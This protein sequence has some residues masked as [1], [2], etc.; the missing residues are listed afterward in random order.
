MVKQP[1]RP[2]NPIPRAIPAHLRELSADPG[3]ATGVPQQI[4]ACS[5]L[6]G[7]LLLPSSSVSQECLSEPWLQKQQR[8]KLRHRGAA[9]STA[10][11]GIPFQPFH[12]WDCGTA[13]LSPCRFHF[14]LMLPPCVQHPGHVAM[15][16]AG[17][18]S[19]TA[20]TKDLGELGSVS[21]IC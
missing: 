6:S 10:H 16:H 2:R 15:P 19:R 17:V 18:T 1:Q 8:G 13:H 14:Q 21:H 5:V 4:W 9:F 11:W 3:A 12:R 20:Q 7:L